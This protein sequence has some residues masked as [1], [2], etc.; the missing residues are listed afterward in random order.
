MEGLPD[1]GHSPV[2]ADQAQQALDETGRLSECHAEK[3]LHRKARLDG[4]IAVGLL[5]AA[6]AVRHSIP[7][8][9]GVESDRQRATALERFPRHRARTGG[10]SMAR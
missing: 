8:Y 6:L 10:A 7:V 3:N 1:E 5:P 9:L 4:G 2:Q